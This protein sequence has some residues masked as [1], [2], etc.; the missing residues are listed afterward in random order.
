MRLEFK[1]WEECWCIGCLCESCH[2]T[3]TATACGLTLL[4]IFLKHNLFLSFPLL[5]LMPSNYPQRDWP[6]SDSVRMAF[7]YSLSLN[8]ISVKSRQWH[9]GPMP[10]YA[11]H[12]CVCV[13][14]WGRQLLATLGGASSISF[15]PVPT[16]SPSLYINTF[17]LRTTWAEGLFRRCGLDLETLQKCKGLLQKGQ[18]GCF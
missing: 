5:R 8:G 4:G 9:C 12:L 18:F 1:A 13:C 16:P 14:A 10:F 3:T 6:V 11:S 15:H 7:P 2:F 17:I